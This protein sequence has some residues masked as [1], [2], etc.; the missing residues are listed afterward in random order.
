M[1]FK[2]YTQTKIEPRDQVYFRLYESQ[3]SIILAAVNEDGS[4][5]GD[6]AILR[7]DSN[8]LHPFSN[9]GDYLGLPLDGENNHIKIIA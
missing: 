8:G 4:E 6:G 2:V 1:K 5:I 9:I 7:I 3:K